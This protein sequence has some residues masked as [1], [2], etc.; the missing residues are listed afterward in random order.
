M[1]IAMS[2]AAIALTVCFG[3]PAASDATGMPA[4]NLESRWAEAIGLQ[5]M[6]S[7]SNYRGTRPESVAMIDA[8]LEGQMGPGQGWFQPGRTRLGWKWLA[9]RMD[10]DGDGLVTA[11]EFLGSAEFFKRLDRNGDGVLTAADFDWSFKPPPAPPKESRTGDGKADA[12]KSGGGMPSREVFLQGLFNGEI[13]SPYEGPRV[14]QRAP[15]FVLP[16]HDGAGTVA[17]ADHI[18]RKPVVLIFGSLT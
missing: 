14:G 7:A 15:R 1:T 10:A 12:A 11:D 6:Y 9:S 13:G 16:T 5:L 4:P 3:S 17:L 18:G 8:I 2:S